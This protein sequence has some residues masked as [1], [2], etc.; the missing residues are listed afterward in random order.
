MGCCG[1]NAP[2]DMVETFVN[3][4]PKEL[5][6]K[7][8]IRYPDA[9]KQTARVLATLEERG[10][11]SISKTHDDRETLINDAA[12][13]AIERFDDYRDVGG[14]RVAFHARVERDGLSIDRT[15]TNAQF[16]VPLAASLFV[17]KAA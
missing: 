2:L 15:V 1:R 14:V 3:F 5:W 8:V 9:A 16:N 7:R 13:K 11:V 10:F 12:Q 6:P 17:K 4:R